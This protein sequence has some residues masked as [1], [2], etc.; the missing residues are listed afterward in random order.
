MALLKGGS[1]EVGSD[2]SDHNYIKELIILSF[3]LI[4]KSTQEVQFANV[5]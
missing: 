1:T 4:F 3:L 2:D 5:I